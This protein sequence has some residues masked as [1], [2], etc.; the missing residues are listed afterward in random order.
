MKIV[1]EQV[2]ILL[3]R[4]DL[5]PEEF[6]RPFESRRLETKWNEVLQEGHFNRV[7][8]FLIKR[9]YVKL[10][11]KATQEIMEGAFNKVE[12]FLIMRKFNKLQRKATQEM[13]MQT[14]MNDEPVQEEFSF[15]TVSRAAKTLMNTPRMIMKQK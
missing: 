10:K 14:I 1:S 3:E 9:K 4:M 15:D 11:R 12:R 8:K 6:V 5:Y 2:K 13:I 7:E